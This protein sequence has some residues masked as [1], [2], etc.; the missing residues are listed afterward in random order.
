MAINS[1]KVFYSAFG[2]IAVLALLAIPLGQLFSEHTRLALLLAA[3]GTITLAAPIAT[4]MV[5]KYDVFHPLN[6]MALSL[7]FGV[8]GRILYIIFASPTKVSQLLEGVP[9][10]ELVPGAILSMIGSLLLSIGYIVG[11]NY[12]LPMPYFGKIL[13]SMNLQRL[14][15]LLPV[16]FIICVVANYFFLKATEA[17]FRGLEDLSQK[18]RVVINEV[19]SSLGYYRL[20]AQDVPRV[21]LFVLIGACCFMQRPNYWLLGF[22][23]IFGL[24]SITLPF[25]SSSRGSVLLALIGCCVV[26]HKARGISVPTLTVAFIIALVIIFGMLALRRVGSRGQSVRESIAEMGLDPLFNNHSFADIVKLA[27]IYNAVPS[28][29]DYKYGLSFIAITYAPIP[30]VIWE[31]KPPISM[32]REITE[33]LYNRGMRLEDKGGGTPPGIFGESIINFSIYGFPIAVFI[34]G[35]VVRWLHNALT[36]YQEESI[37]GL[38]L[39][40]GVMPAY[41]LNLLGGDFTRALT[42]SLAVV[43]ILLLLCFS[44]RFKLIV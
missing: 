22:T 37:A 2:A 40:A 10:H 8:F 41:C 43:L 29:I 12:K 1:S 20:V 7:F 15:I 18:R 6:F 34:M 5:Q 24:L 38:A 36:G 44:T 3:C 9:T 25:L 31:N 13:E 17:E 4:A 39:Y 26:I 27:A 35:L 28:Q 21:V 23:G 33:K 30:R 32:G 16:I 11:G 42:Q 19:E 14:L